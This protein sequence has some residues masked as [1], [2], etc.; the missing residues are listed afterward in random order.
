VVVVRPSSTLAFE[1]TGV[2]IPYFTDD[3][4]GKTRYHAILTRGCR[5]G[6]GPAESYSWEVSARYSDLERLRD[7]LRRAPMTRR[8]PGKER[9]ATLL[10]QVDKDA[11]RRDL[12]SWLRAACELAHRGG[13]AWMRPHLN[14]FLRAPPARRDAAA[15]GAGG[16]G[17]AA[18]GVC[19]PVAAAAPIAVATPVATCVA[20]PAP[21]PTP[22]RRVQVQ[23]PAGARAGELL[24]V[25]GHLGQAFN[26][27]APPGVAPGTLFAV[28]IPR[29]ATSTPVAY[30]TPVATSLS[31]R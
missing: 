5:D 26:V 21:V 8:F 27:P 6:G 22:P 10:G 7:K 16:G 2:Q 12:E 17:A 28:D 14:A 1:V 19:A 25:T 24:E 13:N 11:R 31:P 15:G 9:L 23:M 29:E 4:D 30:G 3:V 18:R 20:T